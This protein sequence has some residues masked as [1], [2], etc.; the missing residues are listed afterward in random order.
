[1]ATQGQ[2]H[3]TRI[4]GK[5]SGTAHGEGKIVMMD[6]TLPELAQMEFRG[7][8]QNMQDVEEVEGGD[9]ESLRDVFVEGFEEGFAGPRR[10]LIDLNKASLISGRTTSTLRYAINRGD[11]TAEKYG[12]SWVV[13]YDDLKAW[14]STPEL[15]KTGPATTL[16]KERIERGLAQTRAATVATFEGQQI[17]KPHGSTLSIQRV[18]GKIWAKSAKRGWWSHEGTFDSVEQLQAWLDT[19]EQNLNR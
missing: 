17:T 3:R 9:E 8:W 7:Y 6:M 5:Q 16:D 2:I 1:M 11:L 14:M 18:D 15:H 13:K 10:A 19:R 12:G 4:A